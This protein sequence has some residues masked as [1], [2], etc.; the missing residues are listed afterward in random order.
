M[1]TGC[2]GGLAAEC[3]VNAEFPPVQLGISQGAP[4]LAG[5]LTRAVHEAGAGL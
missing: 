4:G 5:R 3:G 2:P 1:P